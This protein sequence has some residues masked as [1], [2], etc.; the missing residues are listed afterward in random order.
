M[1]SGSLRLTLRLAYL[2]QVALGENVEE[3]TLSD[4]GHSDKTA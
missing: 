4:I 3:G 1:I 2:A